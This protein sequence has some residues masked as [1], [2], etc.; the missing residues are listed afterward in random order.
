ML[1]DARRAVL[2]ALLLAI[3]QPLAAQGPDSV[4]L[5]FGWKPGMQAQVE[6]EQVRFGGGF[7]SLRIASTY[8]IEVSPHDEG[9]LVAY[10]GTRYTELPRLEG[11][12]GHFFQALSRTA[13]GGKP[14]MVVTRGGE[15][16][17]VQGIERIAAELREAMQPLMAELDGTGARA[18]RRTMEAML[19]DEALAE[20]S[21]KEWSSLVEFWVDT[22]LQVG[23]TFE[24]EEV[25][26]VPLF[27]GIDVPHVTEFRVVGRVPCAAGETERRCVEIV[28]RATV[29]PE[30][31]MQ[32]IG[33]MLRGAGPSDEGLM[34]F[35]S[36][37]SV[38]TSSRLVT[39]PGTLRPHLL[40]ARKAV[41]M[42]GADEP[43]QIEIE[44]YVFRWGIGNRE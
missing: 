30:V 39:E 34:E 36:Q 19:S 38:E 31:L 37:L 5:R 18:L 20:A 32:T 27:P 43:G 6:Y 35:L 33:E 26:Q 15:F 12:A 21:A 8:R 17:R 29:G 22:D 44:R 41:S 25:L 23:E 42:A 4:R 11:P 14:E 40:E 10:A 2:A 13:S 28:A 9:L 16:V 7:D 3:A 24:L 1:S